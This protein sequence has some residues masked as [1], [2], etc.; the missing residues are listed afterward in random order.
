M[1]EPNTPQAEAALR[2]IAVAFNRPGKAD[3]LKVYNRALGIWRERPALA[4]TICVYT[5]YGEHGPEYREMTAR[6]FTDAV[7]KADLFTGHTYRVYVRYTRTCGVRRYWQVVIQ[8]ADALSA[9]FGFTVQI[10]TITL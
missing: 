3:H 5:G 1:Y 9:P 8:D 6:D 7:G 2:T 10:G 4:R